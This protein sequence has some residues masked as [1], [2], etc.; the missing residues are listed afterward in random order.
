MGIEVGDILYSVDGQHSCEVLDEKKVL[1]NEKTMSLTK[2]TRTM[3]DNDYNV[4]PGLYWNYNGKR[5][6]A[7]YNDTYD[8][9][10]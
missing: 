10:D 4:A 9:L 6:R 2:A 3:L 7:I 5:L 1:Y 8:Y